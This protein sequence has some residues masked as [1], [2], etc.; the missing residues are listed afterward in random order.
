MAEAR[1][2]WGLIIPLSQLDDLTND[3]QF[4]EAINATNQE[5]EPSGLYLTHLLRD[6]QVILQRE[7]EGD[8][9]PLLRPETRFLKLFR[10]ATI[11]LVL[12]KMMRGN[13]EE[14]LSD[15]EFL[16]RYDRISPQ[17][18]EQALG[19]AIIPDVPELVEAF[20]KARPTVI[21]ITD[22]LSSSDETT[23]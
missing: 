23:S 18:L 20:N 13:D 10:P 12:T 16:I 7:W 6:D 2:A 3:A 14:D 9:I 22:R 19:K 8:I 11:D 17:S 21:D 5:L 15:I 4:W 1:C